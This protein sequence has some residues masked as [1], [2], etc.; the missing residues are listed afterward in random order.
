MPATDDTPAQATKMAV[1]ARTFPCLTKA[2]GVKPWDA[3]TLDQWALD[4]LVSHGELVTAQF[5]L[6]VW[7]PANTWRCGRFDVMEALRVWDTAHLAAFLAWAN[8]PWW[9]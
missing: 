7:D 9:P 4:A 8:D 5:L 1:F 3:N 2:A 6:A